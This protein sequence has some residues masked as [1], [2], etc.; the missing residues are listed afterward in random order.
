MP[1]TIYNQDWYDSTTD[2]YPWIQDTTEDVH[3]AEPV[4]EPSPGAFLPTETRW[5]TVEE[6][7]PPGT[8]DDD[9]M[10]PPWIPPIDG[11]Q[12][13]VYL[14]PWYV[15]P[16]SYWP[17]VEEPP[18]PNFPIGPATYLI[19]PSTP[20][21]QEGIGPGSTSGSSSQ[22]GWTQQQGWKA[23]QGWTQGAGQP[24]MS[25]WEHFYTRLGDLFDRLSRVWRS[26]LSGSLPVGELGDPRGS[27]FF[28][29]L[30]L[31]LLR[32]LENRVYYPTIQ[33]W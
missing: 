24:D 21:F 29:P 27:L 23:G 28:N 6:P 33:S 4:T 16:G 7:S 5:P 13:S 22:G 9:V 12:P 19:S 2:Y 10:P 1:E 8:P 32:R 30:P 26:V 17:T 31:W 3:V 18:P 14:W 15:P 11:S 20:A 25:R